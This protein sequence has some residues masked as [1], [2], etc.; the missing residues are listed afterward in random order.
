MAHLGRC[1]QAWTT[2]ALTNCAFHAGELDRVKLGA[3]VFEDAAARRRLN[4]ATH[5]PILVEMVRQ[6]AGLW[7]SCYT[8]AVS[9]SVSCV[10][11]RMQKRI[12]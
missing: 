6:I 7:A 5:L 12:A 10:I 11:F 9:S 8:V 1:L 3:V 2:Q 4:T